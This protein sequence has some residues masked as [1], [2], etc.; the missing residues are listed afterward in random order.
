[1]SFAAIQNLVVGVIVLVC[2]L[3]ALRHLAPRWCANVQKRIGLWLVRDS[4]PGWVRRLALVIQP[5]AR[6]DSACGSGCNNCG[7]PAQEMKSPLRR[8]D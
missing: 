6:A 8:L 5:A 4:R 7:T 2:A 3:S 1:M